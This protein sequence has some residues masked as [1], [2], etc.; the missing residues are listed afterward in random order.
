M[1]KSIRVSLEE[2]E[3][4]EEEE[5]LLMTRHGESVWRRNVASIQLK[6]WYVLS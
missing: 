2:E 1:C 6:R 3:E 4:E 5:V